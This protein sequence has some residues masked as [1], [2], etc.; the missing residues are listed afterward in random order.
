[1]RS[2]IA[3]CLVASL[4][5]ASVRAE[6]PPSAFVESPRVRRQER[7]GGWV[8]LSLASLN[9]AVVALGIGYLTVVRRDSDAGPIFEA[10]G[11]T[12]T[13]GGGAIAFAL[14]GAGLACLRESARL[15]DSAFLPRTSARG[16]AW[17]F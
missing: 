16:L 10:I 9:F 14:L 4:L 12:M 7:V 13:V 11:T 6:P 1:M 2:L 3:A 17:R 5:A 15:R 8:L